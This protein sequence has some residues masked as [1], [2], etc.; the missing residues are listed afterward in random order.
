M[1][2]PLAAIVLA[3]GLGTRMR[4]TRAKVLHQLAGEPMIAR[5]LRAFASVGPRP[6]VV[7]V[8]Y[9]AD[10]VRDAARRALPGVTD[11]VFAAQPRQ[12]GT[13][14]AARYGLDAL[15]DVFAGYVLIGYGDMPRLSPATLRAFVAEHRQRGTKLSFISVKL[16]DA[17]LLRE[18]LAE[19]RPDNAQREYY[20][21]DIVAIARRRDVA[22]EA[23]QAADAAEFA[24]INSREELAQMEAQIRNEVNRRLMA[25]GVTL[26]DP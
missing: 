24:G 12:R 15:A 6:V 26:V 1:E 4:S 25:S 3:A 13:G 7:V 22:V 21:T 18:A 17:A 8:G 11:L 23:W 10:E 5:T 2:R 20:L 16:A 14:D 9:D 19:L